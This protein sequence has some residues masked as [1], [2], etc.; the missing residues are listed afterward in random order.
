VKAG[1]RMSN[2]ESDSEF[3]KIESIL[4]ALAKLFSEIQQALDRKSLD[5]AHEFLEFNNIGF[6][7]KDNCMIRFLDSASDN[8]DIEVLPLL[9]LISFQRYQIS[10][11]VVEFAIIEKNPD[12]DKI[13][14]QNSLYLSK[15]GEPIEKCRYARIK[16]EEKGHMFVEFQ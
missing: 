13:N 16:I 3:V 15:R 5:L 4:Y 6:S 2:E 14:S 11:L 12:F 10:E 9:S 1:D 7:F 8:T